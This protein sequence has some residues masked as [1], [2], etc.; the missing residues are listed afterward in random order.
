[1]YV[2]VCIYTSGRET[3]V[4]LADS[5]LLRVRAALSPSRAFVRLSVCGWV[6]E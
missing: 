5:G 3:E 4:S 1:M 2:C 6:G